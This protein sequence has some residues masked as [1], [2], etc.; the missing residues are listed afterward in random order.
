MA[1]TLRQTKGS[2]LTISE[3]D[4]NFTYAADG[5]YTYTEVEVS[6]AQILAMGSTP[7]ELLPAPGA[8]SY[9]L[10]DNVI[11]EYTHN[12]TAYTMAATDYVVV[13]GAQQMSA[14]KTILT[15]TNNVQTVMKS[16]DGIDSVND[17]NFSWVEGF[18]IPL[19]LYGWDG[20][21]PT[22]GDGT[23]LVKIWYKEKTFGTEL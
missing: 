15:S 14:E 23:L 17:V 18:N 11:L 6:S 4:A 7:I 19:E 16:S 20:S 22:L 1:L 12:T 3:M 5:G 2:P 13:S 9:Y 10:T 21:N 8:N